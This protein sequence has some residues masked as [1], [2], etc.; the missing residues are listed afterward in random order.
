MMQFITSVNPFRIVFLNRVYFRTVAIISLLLLLLLLCGGLL[1]SQ[2]ALAEIRQFHESPTAFPGSLLYKSQWSL[3]D[4][5]GRTWQAIAFQ[6]RSTEAQPTDPLVIKLRL[7]GFPGSVAIDPTKP[8]LLDHRQGQFYTAAADAAFTLHPESVGQ[9]EL[10]PILSQLD[11]KTALYLSV[12]T[13]DGTTVD[14]K[15]PPFLV[16]EWVSLGDR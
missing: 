3:V 6:V 5:A 1:F 12:A 14:L 15:V 2:P 13:T 16:E 9:F 4:Q 10:Q 7:V 8:L 11:P